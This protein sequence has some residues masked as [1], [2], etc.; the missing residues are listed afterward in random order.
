MLLVP[1]VAGRGTGQISTTGRLHDTLAQVCYISR[2][3]IQKDIESNIK[4]KE[5]ADLASKLDW[6]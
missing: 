4:I 3:A 1:V 5:T 6:E 2:Y